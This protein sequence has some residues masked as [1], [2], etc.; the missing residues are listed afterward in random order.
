MKLKNLNETVPASIASLIIILIMS[1]CTGNLSAQENDSIIFTEKVNGGFPFTESGKSSP[2]LISGSDYPGVLRVLNLFKTDIK[3]V[4][5]NEPAVF[6]DT[7]PSADNLVIIGSVDKSP[8]IAGL[9]AKGKLNVDEIKGKWEASLIQTIDNPFPGIK[10]ALVIAGSDK[11]GTIYG[12]FDISKK[13]GVSPWYYWAD[14]PVK[15][16]DIIYVKSGKHILESPKVKYRG[17]F[18]NDEAPAL[19]GWAEENFGG[20]NHKFY[21][22]VFELILRLKGNFLWPAMWGRAFYD[23][24]PENPVLAND[25][26]VV[27]NFS[28]HEPMM[29][30]HDEWRRYGTGP[31]NYNKNEKELKKFWMEGIRRMDGNESII[32]VGMR[33][34]G[35]EPMSEDANVALLQ[36]IVSD[37]R[38]IIANVTGKDVTTVPQVW[39]LYKEVQE[40]YDKGMRV[41]D[42]VTLLLCDDNWGN[43]RKLP[44]VGEK[45]R[46]GGY[47]VYYHFDY[48]GGPRNYKWLNTNQIERTWEQMHLAYEM[49]AR[50]IWIVNVGDLKPMEFP[51]SFFL[52]YA[53]NPDKISAKQLPDY[54]KKWAAEQFGNE[55]ADETAYILNKYTKYNSRRKPELLN[56]NTYSLV[57]CREFETVVS[58]YY[59]IADKA[60]EIYNKLPENYKDSYYQLVVHPTEACSNLND[61]YFTV[62]KNHLYAKQ[63][64]AETNLMAKKAKKLFEKDAEITDYYN[65]K[66]SGG[67]WNHIMD[68]THIGYTYWQ[69]PDEN[70]MPEV[71]TIDIPETAAMGVA[72]EGL[73]KSW[74]EENSDAVLPEFDSFSKG[75]FYIDIFNRGTTPFACSIE[76]GVSWI[77]AIAD[78]EMVA[79]GKRVFINVD[80]EHAPEGNYR[81]PIKIK[82]PD[83]RIITVFAVVKNQP[84]P[85]TDGAGY[86]AESNGYIS[87][88]SE[89]IS[90]SIS[91]NSVHWERIP[92][93]GRTSSAMTPFPVTA[94]P[95]TPG[96]SSSRLEY[97]VYLSE[98]GTVKVNAYLSPTLNFHNNQG[99]RYGI[100]FDDEA[101]QII[102]MHENMSFQDWEKSVAQNIRIK[103]STHQINNPGFH[104]LKFWAVDPGVDLQKIVIN[105]GGEPDTYLGPPQSTEV[106]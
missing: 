30:S 78:K 63:G 81:V 47:G 72:V 99:L 79:T 27:I 59:E 68:Q 28:H 55:Y 10:K 97:R 96:G 3:N 16:H 66:L 43:I 58:D 15:K 31:W 11:R 38:E 22:H 64:R 24:D 18:L 6:K 8:V 12:M 49:N 36:R 62:A 40:Y 83:D 90:R 57:N 95:Q 82:G 87:I 91:A 61:L 88:E 89:N 93:L 100:S 51:I 103:T 29:R 56:E 69:Q 33:G 76:P 9:V 71:Q 20:F 105:A 19:S 101:P 14:V 102:N 53:W 94:E 44:K 86:F 41:P 54:T 21:D 65:H 92:N 85:T 52:D 67:K 42:D 74:P 34:D 106:K 5:G 46:K 84:V 23:D 39:A 4:T 50:E 70:S 48:V 98:S 80:W 17:I 13:I 1:V 7:I 35:D 45:P 2:V 32:T 73:E 37:Q 26:G 77:T 104:T 60:Q 25:Y 75:R